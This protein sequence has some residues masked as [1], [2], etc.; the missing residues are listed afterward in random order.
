MVL[1]GGTAGVGKTRLVTELAVEA[2]RAGLLTL[3]GN[4]Y[5]REDSVPFV[6]FV[7]ILETALERAPNHSAFRALLGAE[8]AEISRLLPE[9]RRLYSDIPATIELPPA[10]SQRMLLN[11]VCNILSRVASDK[12]VLVLLED[13][14]WADQGTLALALHLA[15]NINKVPVLI[16]GTYRDDDLNSTDALARTLEE[17]I[18][19]DLAEQIGL[20]G[21]PPNAVAEMVQSLG[22]L[23]PS[24]TLVGLLYKTTDGNPF[25]VSELFRHLTEHGKLTGLDHKT[26]TEISREALDLPQSLRLVIGRRVNRVGDET[27]SMLATAAVIGRSFSIA[28]LRAAT[29]VDTDSLIDRLEEAEKS[30]ALSSEILQD[31]TQFNFAHELIRRVILDELPTARRQRI[32]LAVAT[33]LESLH[34]GTA[35]DYASELAYHLWKADVFADAAKTVHYLLPHSK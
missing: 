5:D 16:V 28:L 31:E 26:G 8:A 17:L 30:G 6:P 15:R 7:E 34:P 33:A 27:R 9:V 35:E 32:H 11:A 25:Y 21:L 24:A 3:V 22:G 4:C 29:H 20:R 2:E 10:Q 12:P 14:Q 18:R 19:L 13:L 1:I 23:E